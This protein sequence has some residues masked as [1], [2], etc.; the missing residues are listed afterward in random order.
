MVAFGLISFRTVPVTPKPSFKASAEAHLRVSYHRFL[1]HESKLYDRGENMGHVNGGVASRFCPECVSF[2]PEHTFSTFMYSGVFSHIP[3]HY[4]AI[5]KT[6]SAFTQQCRRPN[7]E[8]PNAFTAAHI[9]SHARSTFLS[10]RLYSAYS[11]SL[12]SLALTLKARVG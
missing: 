3:I 6:S 9:H 12:H 2:L 8:C 10:I 7:A 1:P 5:L 11:R 4:K